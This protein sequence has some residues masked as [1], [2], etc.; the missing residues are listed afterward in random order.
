MRADANSRRRRMVA[1]AGSVC[2]ALF[3]A[4]VMA[5]VS[6]TGGGNPPFTGIDINRF[7]G[8][9]TFYNHGYTGSR[10]IITSIDAGHIWN[11][12]ETLRHVTTF[13][14][15]PDIPSPNGDVDRHATWVAGV[16]G[17]RTTGASYA[18]A[19]RG[20]AHDAELWSGSVATLWTGTPYTLAFNWNKNSIRHPY[21]TA[22]IGGVGGRTTD[23]V[24]SSWGSGIVR[25]NSLFNARLVDALI[26]QSGKVVV[27]GA[28][29]F[30][31]TATPQPGAYA[32]TFNS[33]T[34]GALASD[35]SSP[36]YGARDS[37]SGY[38]PNNFWN[39]Q[40][41]SVVPGVVAS[42]DLVAPGSNLTLPFYGG[43]TG[44]NTNGTPQAGDALYSRNSRGASF[45]TPQVA[46]G[47]ALVVDA[48]KALFGGGS[49][50]DGRVV[51]AVLQ[52]SATKI[53]GWNNGQTVIAGLVTT[54]QSL[55]Y[56]LGAGR[57]NLDSAY[58]QYTSG[59]TDVPGL[60]G[61]SIKAVGWDFGEAVDSATTDYSFS[62]P[63]RADSAMTA[64]LNWFLDNSYD[65]A[66]DS[67]VDQSL[68]N[69]DLEVWKITPGSREPD[70]L[71]AQSKGTYNNVEHLTFMLP[72]TAKYLLRVR[73]NGEVFDTVN[74]E[75]RE[76]FGLA[77][78]ATTALLG[79]AD[80]NGVVN[81]D[82]FM[83]LWDCF[84]EPGSFSEGD[85]NLNGMVD[86]GDFQILELNWGR[87]SGGTIDST[88]GAIPVVPEPCGFIAAAAVTMLLGRA[89]RGRRQI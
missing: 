23:V 22:M 29:N 78:S 51:K 9:E 33:I 67:L 28:G 61:G 17:G 27:F 68:D 75:N 86:F 46:A 65:Y 13:F 11:G 30:G 35:T 84:G 47:A 44:G 58:V 48:G 63:L 6:S 19:Q 18:D 2:L 38:G 45:A 34:V 69:L 37:I 8:A 40:T 52:N 24:N 20:I 66:G 89:R 21:Y 57:L 87:T 26:N 53:G 3:P 49:S 4:R 77:W 74:D 5:V 81:H 88:V 59:T 56:R 15:N 62:A 60:G 73:W 50:I 16:L 42:V 41:Q 54:T 80:G 55:D 79:D 36:P 71:V 64:T 32:S 31:E 76:V 25:D 70:V 43:A 83:R 85:F 82:D 7:I 1:A 72:E 39:P 14:D 12:H 10:A